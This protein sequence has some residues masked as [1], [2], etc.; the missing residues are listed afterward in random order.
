MPPRSVSRC[1]HHNQCTNVGSLPA[2][3][4]NYER[5]CCQPH[6]LE[7]WQGVTGRSRTVRESAPPGDVREAAEERLASAAGSKNKQL[8][9]GPLRSRRVRVDAEAQT[10]NHLLRRWRLGG[11]RPGAASAAGNRRGEPGGAATEGVVCAGG[12][13]RIP[14]ESVAGFA[15]GPLAVPAGSSELPQLLC[16]HFPPTHANACSDSPFVLVQRS[17]KSPGRWR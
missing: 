15:A 4:L 9:R 10:A 12:E 8:G 13:Q 17:P 16:P 1:R 11:K 5:S 7:R 2:L 14:W 6:W 3:A